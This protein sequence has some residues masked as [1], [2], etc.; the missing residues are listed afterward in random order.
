MNG[1]QPVRLV[2]LG[3]GY[4]DASLE[5]RERLFLEGDALVAG[6][7]A[8]RRSFDDGARGLLLEHVVLSTCNRFEIYAVTADAAR[9]EM[10]LAD[11]VGALHGLS[12]T[13]LKVSLVTRRDEAV[14]AHLMRV[15]AGLDSM[16]LGEPQILGQVAGT[17]REASESGGAGP[18]LQRLFSRALRTGKRVRSETDISRH[19][20][21]VGHAAAILATRE[22]GSPVDATA[23]VV[24]AGKIAGLAA[25]ALRAQGAGTIEIASRTRA[26]AAALAAEVN[27]RVRRWDELPAAVAAAD[28]VIAATAAPRPVIRA[29]P[30]RAW[31]QARRGPPVVLVDLALPRDVEPAVRDLPG[32]VCFDLDDLTSVVGTNLA[33]RRAA[34]PAAEVIFK[35][36]M[37][38]FAEWLSVRE[39]V[40]ALVGMRSSV[41][42]IADAELHAALRR[43][44]HL[45]P[46]DR[47]VV[48]RLVDRIVGKVLHGPTINL[49]RQAVSGR[50]PEHARAVRN[51]FSVRA[52]SESDAAPLPGSES[53]PSEIPKS[54]AISDGQGT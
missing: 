12:A 26:S 48:E 28:I 36:E 45:N 42:A 7:R 35:Q 10:A 19:S 39:V 14:V 32:V 2:F 15:A 17:L 34:L 40:P 47:A 5:I 13:D 16:I 6:L 50:G 4:R 44:E 53:T 22:V 18:V 23:L 46:P 29:A 9:A 24:G 49:R 25:R 30:L 52:A 41:R 51:L 38:T 20:L 3:A 37:A 21:S 31:L 11:I 54:G 27:G 33:R 43:L 8:M 1:G